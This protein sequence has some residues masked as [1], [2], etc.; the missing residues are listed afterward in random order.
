MA[1][2]CFWLTPADIKEIDL[3]EIWKGLEGQTVF[4]EAFHPKL[5]LNHGV[6]NGHMRFWGNYYDSND[7]LQ[8]TCHSFPL[9]KK[10]K[11]YSLYFLG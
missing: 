5:P 8:C 9:E 2:N 7:N 11:F 3:N 1:E 10:A 4:A 6:D